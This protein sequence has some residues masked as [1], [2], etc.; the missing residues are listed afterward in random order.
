MNALATDYR[1]WARDPREI[2]DSNADGT[3][4]LLE[5]AGRAGLQRLVYTSSVATLAV[6][7]GDGHRE[8]DLLMRQPRRGLSE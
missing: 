7:C 6:P 8:D 4:H 1:L 2:Y 3:R 5:A